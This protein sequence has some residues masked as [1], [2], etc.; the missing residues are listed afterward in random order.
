MFYDH[1]SVITELYWNQRV[2]V[3]HRF[4]CNFMLSAF[5]YP[6]VSVDADMPVLNPFNGS[7]FGT[8]K[9]LLAMGTMEQVSSLKYAKLG[10]D[11]A[12]V[13]PDKPTQYLER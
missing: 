8:V 4:Y 9:I 7:Q 6:V 5:Q 1:Q 10:Q 3:K 13:V 12:I 11:S 2:V